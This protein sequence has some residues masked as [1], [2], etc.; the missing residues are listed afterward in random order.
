LDALVGYSTLALAGATTILAGVT[1]WNVRQ[2]KALVGETKGLVQ[3]TQDSA[4]AAKQTIG[5]LRKD[6]E[7]EYQPY[8][9]W[10]RVG[11]TTDLKQITGPGEAVV[12]NHGRGPALQCLCCATWMDD[13]PEPGSYISTTDLF[14]LS[15]TQE[16]EERLHRRRNAWVPG[17]E[18]AGAAVAAGRPNRVAFCQDH[19]GTYYRF[20]PYRA[21]V[22][23]WRETDG[24]RPRWLDF[25]LSHFK[26][27]AKD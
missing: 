19:L 7:L 23:S 21:R 18:I 11:A 10:Q 20:V 13:G 26:E 24:G 17:D 14:D 6:R 22:D 3:A 15:P 5:E 16:S 12:V 4:S 2:A 8:L 25:Y 27:L 1:Y 9:S